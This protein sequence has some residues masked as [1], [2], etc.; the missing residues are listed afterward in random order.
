MTRNRPHPSSLWRKRFR[1]IHHVDQAG[2]T[3]MYRNYA[4]VFV[5]T[6]GRSGSR[7][8]VDLL[9][10]CPGLEAFHEPR[11][12]LQYFADFAFHRQDQSELLL[13]MVDAA[14]MEGV[15]EVM[16]RDQVYVESNQ[17]LTFFAPAL[18]GLF[19]AARFVHLVR[20]PGDFVRSAWR[21]GWHRNDSI[22]ESGRIRPQDTTAWSNWGEIEKLAW[23]WSATNDFIEQFKTSVADERFLR[24]RFEDL[25]ADTGILERLAAFCGGG[26][27]ERTAAQALLQSPVNPL[28]IGADEP[29][30][31]KKHADFPQYRD[32]QPAQQEALLRHVATLASHYGYHLAENGGENDK[33]A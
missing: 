8:L 17:C 9:N 32:W 11:P 16:I 12:T 10:L 6:T 13:R 18:A 1:M 20:H 25:V 28:H 27:P 23:V 26:L 15:L 29:P 5:L 30:N 31:M 3:H 24:V 7:L 22:W 19:Q 4:P 21:K 14:R 2:I 33:Q